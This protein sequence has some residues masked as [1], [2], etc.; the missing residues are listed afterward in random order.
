[1]C[2]HAKLQTVLFFERFKPFGK[3]LYSLLAYTT[4]LAAVCWSDLQA[5][6]FSMA[7]TEI[8]QLRAWLHL[9]ERSIQVEE[10]QGY[11]NIRGREYFF[12]DFVLSHLDQLDV[13]ANQSSVLNRMKN[14]FTLY[15]LSSVAERREMIRETR[16]H[17]SNLGKQSQPESARS[18]ALRNSPANRPASKQK[19]GQAEADWRD[20]PVQFVKSVGPKLG[21]SFAKVGVG[22]VGELLSYYPRKHLDYSQCTP[23][24]DLRAGKL[25]TVWGSIYK[26]SSHTPPGKA[27]LAIIKVV[28]RDG[29]GRL[30]LS[31]F[32]RG[33]NYLR[34]Q[35][36]QRFPL[37][38]QIILSG[39][40]K[41]DKYSQGLTL[42][43]P[44]FEVLGDTESADSQ[45]D[46]LH[47]GR[48]VPVYPLTEGLNIKWVRR[49][50]YNALQAYQARISD[51]LPAALIQRLGLM[52]FAEAIHEFH[53]PQS[54]EALR[55]ARN[56]LVFQELL[57]TQL[58]L[59]YRR[60]QQNR[61]QGGLAIQTSGKLAKAFL[62]QLPFSLT[63]A[64]QR[65]YQE[66]LK[67]LRAENPMNRLVQGDV[68]S[69]KTVVAV[70]ALLEAL[71]AG[72]QGALMAPTEI[73]AEQHFQKIFK[74]L[75][76][77]NL[78]TELLI[79]S[80][81]AKQKRETL[82]RLAS[83][84]A[85]LIIGTHALIQ[86]GVNFAR[87]GL[88]VIDEQHRF[89]VKQRA[90]L[91][92][93]GQM[94]EILS[95][96]ATPIPRTLALTVYG[97]L[98]VSQIDELPPGRKPVETKLVRGSQREQTWEFM[99]QEMDAGRQC[100]VVFPLVEESEKMDL[101]AA[102]IEYERYREHIF[103]GYK[104]GLLHGKMK[105]VE[106]EAGMRAFVNNEHQL[107]IATTV[108][109]VGVDVPNA[110]VMI[111]EHAER[112]GLA[113]LHQLRGRV[114]RGADRSYCFLISD[115]LSEIAKERLQIFT[116]TQDGFVIAEQDLR[117]RGPGE[118]LGTRQSG[119]PDLLLT[120]LVED[121]QWLELARN[122]ARLIISADPELT[123]LQHRAL[124][125]EVYRFFKRH[126]SS[127]EA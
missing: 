10:K 9:F 31:F 63:G 118:F 54:E 100:Y 56:R 94:P 124:K 123:Q 81:G 60:E 101:K 98:D 50:I 2:E 95:M 76:P 121:T 92:A 74:W 116:Q 91:K 71:E 52:G 88:A 38:A 85:H 1:M 47:L 46:S 126:L 33:G 57:L 13:T 83:G 12:A 21:E 77:L 113:Q 84:E 48:I 51:P 114:G 55:N 24:A 44:E 29:T 45:A 65:V 5:A 82:A 86:E 120:N 102:T 43:S 40:V 17:L 27:H 59:L 80:Q 119:L 104:V 68:G 108:I 41:W 103:P 87:L 8:G 107:L 109:E 106:K 22:T 36:E 96:T 75:L 93:K 20:V 105:G 66:I 14:M 11:R 78:Q 89:G 117:L 122:E 39:T 42:D 4:W 125:G 23:I 69:G 61:Q 7:L 99:R 28:I 16:Q 62:A 110:S 25:A 73:L 49:A 32:Q 111:I 97:D 6:G 18:P 70:L 115:K 15:P 30:N 64:Q 67:D 72:Y 79:G 127:L 35:F 19:P 90:T 26:V 53:F 3:Q 34:R 58:G 37:N 112:F